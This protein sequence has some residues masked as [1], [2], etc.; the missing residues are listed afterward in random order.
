MHILALSAMDSKALTNIIIQ[1]VYSKDREIMNTGATAVPYS[2]LMQRLQ[3][4][5]PPFVLLM[6]TA[7]TKLTSLK[8][9]YPVGRKLYGNIP[10]LL[11]S[12]SS[13]SIQDL[14]R[15]LY[16]IQPSKILEPV[17]PRYPLFWQ[18]P[19]FSNSISVYTEL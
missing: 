3:G 1:E 16:G 15:V 11:P 17:N 7:A 8:I 2:Y 9:C 19:T 18:Q 6:A 5:C 4:G 13:V 12:V 14:I 10:R